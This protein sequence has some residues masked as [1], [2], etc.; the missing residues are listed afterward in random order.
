MANDGIAEASR[1][2]SFGARSGVAFGQTLKRLG[3]RHSETPSRPRTKRP[4]QETARRRV[5]G[6]G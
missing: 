4:R 1:S 2:G 6:R 3:Q 5:L